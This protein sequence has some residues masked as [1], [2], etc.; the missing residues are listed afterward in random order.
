MCVLDKYGGC[1]VCCS[2]S[3]K[4]FLTIVHINDDGGK[5]RREL[6]GIKDGSAYQWYLKL[7]REDK[8]EDLRVLCFNCN[9]G[10]RINGG[11]C[12]HEQQKTNSKKIQIKHNES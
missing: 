6:Y 8:R 4:I 7:K 10:R 3:E 11:V 1:C 2:E 9:C 5:E 12:P